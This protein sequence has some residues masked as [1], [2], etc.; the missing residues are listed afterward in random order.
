MKLINMLLEYQLRKHIQKNIQD[1][2]KRTSVGEVVCACQ[3]MS[4]SAV[5]NVMKY[6]HEKS[7]SIPPQQAAKHRQERIKETDTLYCIIFTYPSTGA[8]SL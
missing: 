7:K 3:L 6:S 1:R 4:V 5:Q 2:V 8:F